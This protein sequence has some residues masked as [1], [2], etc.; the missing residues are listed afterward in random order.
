MKKLK[1]VFFIL[2]FPAAAAASELEVINSSYIDAQ[3][4]VSF[5]NI[6][7]IDNFDDGT[8][9][10][11]LGGNMG[12]FYAGGAKAGVNIT[13]TE[14]V[15]GAGLSIAYDVTA[16]DSFCGYWTKMRADETPRD[17][18]SFDVL[19]FYVRG[20]EGGELFK[21]QFS[22]GPGAR[23]TSSVYIND[24]LDG[25]V[26]RSW[27]KVRIPFNNFTSIESMH[28]VYELAVVFEHTS[29]QR[30]P[31]SSLTGEIFMDNIAVSGY[32]APEMRLAHFG[33]GIN[34]N[35]T[36]GEFGA[37]G[38]PSGSAAESFTTDSPCGTPYALKLDYDINRIN[39][40]AGIWG[41]VSS[42]REE[43]HFQGYDTF[44]FYSKADEGGNP[45]YLKIELKH[46]DG[47]SVAVVEGIESEWK[48]FY[49]PF[50]TFTP[51]FDGTLKEWVFI[52]DNSN[53]TDREGTVYFDKIQFEDSEYIEDISAP[54]KPR[55]MTL[56]SDA[57]GTDIISRT[58]FSWINRIAVQADSSA[59]DPYM[60]AVRFEYRTGPGEQ[61]QSIGEDYNTSDRNY[62]IYWDTSL[63][64]EGNSYELRAVAKN[65][66]GYENEMEEIA[67][68]SVNHYPEIS[69]LSDEELMELIQKQIFWYFWTQVNP[70]RGIIQDRSR[71]FEWDNHGYTSVA[72]SGMGL[73]AICIAHKREWISF[74][75]AYSRVM[76]ILDSYYNAAES[77]EP[78]TPI[79]AHNKGFFYHWTDF[80]G[81][82]MP[83]SELS[84][85]D[86]S[87]FVAG[88]IFAGEYFAR[89]GYNNPYTI[90]NEIY[91]RIDW[92]WM[93]SPEGY[94]YWGWTPEGGF[95][96]GKISG[97]SEGILAYILAAGAPDPAK[98]IGSSGWSS[99]TRPP[100]K[101]RG[102]EYIYEQALFAHQYTH[103]FV[104][105]HEKRDDFAC[106]AA[107][108]YKAA[109]HHHRYAWD[110]RNLYETYGKY[111]WGFGGADGPDGN[112]HHY[113]IDNNDGTVS[114][115]NLLTSIFFTPVQA[116]DSIRFLYEN[117]KESLWGKY[118]FSDSYNTDPS[119]S[120]YFNEEDMWRSRDAVGVQQGAVFAAIENKRSGIISELF[121]A[122]SHA[123]RA[124]S[125][126]NFRAESSPPDKIQNLNSKDENGNIT[127][128]WTAPSNFGHPGDIT[129]GIYE[130][131]FSTEAAAD[132]EDSP[133]CYLEYETIF[134][135]AVSP[136][137]KQSRL[138]KG[139]PSNNTYY[140]TVKLYNDYFNSGG[141]SNTAY[142]YIEED[143][144]P[145][146]DITDLEAHPYEGRVQLQW[147]APGDDGNTGEIR[148]GKYEIIFTTVSFHSPGEAPYSKTWE[149]NTR[150]GRKESRILS[151]KLMPERRHY[152][153]IRTADAAMN[154]SG[155]S[156]RTDYYITDPFA[157]AAISDLQA[158]TDF[159]LKLTWTAPGDD[160]WEGRA[161]K[162]IVKYS[163]ISNIT[164]YDKWE[165]ASLYSQDWQPLAGGSRESKT[166]TGL[167]PG[168]EI[169]FSIR[170]RD[171]A[172]NTASLSNADDN[173]AAAGY[174]VMHQELGGHEKGDF[175]F[176]D[177]NN[178]GYPDLA[179][180]H[181]AGYGSTGDG[182]KI[183]EN[184]GGFYE[185][186][187]SLGS[188]LG[189]SGIGWVD[190]NSSG[191]MDIAVLPTGR[192]GGATKLYRNE[193]G[194]DF[195]HVQ[196]LSKFDNSD[197]GLDAA[198]YNNTGRKDL[199][200]TG[201]AGSWPGTSVVYRNDHPH[202]AAYT[203]MGE[204]GLPQIQ[205]SNLVFAD[206]NNNG[207]QDIIIN[208][209]LYRNNEG[210]SF[211]LAKTF[212]HPGESPS[213]AWADYNNSG[214]LDLAI[215]GGGV[216]KIY[217]N[218]ED[219]TFTK[220]LKYTSE[221]SSGGFAAWADYN[222]SGY[223]DILLGDA[224][225]TYDNET[226]SFI[227]SQR[228]P[229]ARRAAWADMDNSG[230]ADFITSGGLFRNVAPDYGNINSRPEP[231]DS[232]FSVSTVLY[233]STA[234][235]VFMW[236]TGSDYETPREGLYYSIRVGTEPY[237][238][239]GDDSVVSGAFSSPLLGNH[240][241]PKISNNQP[242]RII[243]GLERGK[244]YYWSVQTIDAGLS[245]SR[246][247]QEQSVYV[248]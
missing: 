72:A 222:N 26:T 48:K 208:N 198:D 230:A 185:H 205:T 111:S 223:P 216:S 70:D 144:V 119:W 67:G 56:L 11:L 77:S 195:S 244:T 138:I 190:Y 246:W 203:Y 2:L 100:G 174:F 163:T 142:S 193:G 240:L 7:L 38:W 33:A 192:F 88:A 31:D 86:T 179:I 83:N 206:Y 215:S 235:V 8:Y 49:V 178:N 123:E 20:K 229:G 34:I 105:L 50:D 30:N 27:Q 121:S 91:R 89:H 59:D 219:H 169:W 243:R 120:A 99:L 126:L 132:W 9:T 36:G 135:T 173:H 150:P 167:K 110:N 226:D 204:M 196:D 129:D 114:L 238:N 75:D 97:Y 32:S 84:T 116:L 225:F 71:N 224:L 231:P 155:F 177:F 186:F 232:G 147:T 63:L 25:G 236:D 64:N 207:W 159:Q 146:A 74:N 156:N 22:T 60:E 188:N 165:Q 217:R 109:V 157:P 194:S 51:G 136:G 172:G 57:E 218:N 61:W 16:A 113:G 104:D 55:D 189:N 81:G 128:S 139:L 17:F 3:A 162:Y 21:I 118:T 122:S 151:E 76:N 161:E 124:L 140:F 212:E 108:S 43:V 228:I 98:R 13:S 210:E 80:G 47:V 42:K 15:S 52:F 176:V 152:F 35:S 79:L 214:R 213:I 78:D 23:Q 180:G 106:Y 184:T 187:L 245:T 154:W 166:L 37:L 202:D 148:N 242:G 137:E 54:E 168:K 158:A 134:S 125:S 39:A 164:S 181:G 82:R 28:A 130:I 46:S 234:T 19:S 103:L 221:N 112:Y 73:A 14:S 45:G 5:P 68:L 143:T 197:S 131:R 247:S 10:N 66:F 141:A 191:F 201:W 93:K 90:A 237:A 211:S 24:F 29:S 160:G 40:F 107:E 85:I 241:R 220:V 153:W 101:Y 95:D 58:E 199:A 209:E 233:G 200:M 4:H 12:A 65:M 133:Y 62:E 183:Y 145:P 239:T 44:S 175:S 1:I 41:M 6:L 115:S 102:L 227:K 117:H 171:S 69:S 182:V 149:A 170:A 248:E 96:Q 92:K 18:S 53:S 94:L 127:L 87:L